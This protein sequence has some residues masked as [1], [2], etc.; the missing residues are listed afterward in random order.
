MTTFNFAPTSAKPQHLYSRLPKNANKEVV[1]MGCCESICMKCQGA[2]MLVTGIVVLA[3]AV[4]QPRYIWHTLGVLIILKGLMHLAKPN[5]C[6]H[7]DMPAAS[8]KKK[9]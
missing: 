6:G 4:W 2:K 1:L 5:G 8:G 9:R 7:C 3:V